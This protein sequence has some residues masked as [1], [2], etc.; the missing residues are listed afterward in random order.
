Y[1]GSPW[2][3]EMVRFNADAAKRLGFGTVPD[4]KKAVAR[5]IRDYVSNGGFLFA[6]CTA[7]ETLD[8]ALAAARVDIAAAFADGTPMDP[9]ADRKLDWS[10]AL[11]FS[12]ARLEPS[13]QVASFSDSEGHLDLLRRARPG[14]SAA[15]DR[16]SADRPV[17]ASPFARLP[18]HPQQRPVPRGQEARAQDVSVERLAPAVRDL[19]RAEIAA[20]HG[21]EVSFVP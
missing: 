18:A 14:R 12:G 7:T 3:A 1:A 8:L 16:R 21:R 11:A 4:L 17:A 10:Q 5:K 2:L 15:P 6:M 20:A 13:P 9:A 19:L